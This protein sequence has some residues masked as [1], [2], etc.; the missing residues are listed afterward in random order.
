MAS[1]NIH[2]IVEFSVSTKQGIR[3]AN[4]KDEIW[5]T[6]HVL[7]VIDNHG[8]QTEINMFTDTAKELITSI[9]NFLFMISNNTSSMVVSSDSVRT[10]N[11]F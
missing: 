8:A 11:I 7:T 2:N 4:E 5:Y 10:D 3:K 6:C 1:V 9:T